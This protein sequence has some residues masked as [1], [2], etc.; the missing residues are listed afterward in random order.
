[1]KN[2][3]G[4]MTGFLIG[5]GSFLLLF[6]FYFL[7]KI[8]PSDEL[9]PGVLVLSAVSFGVVMAYSGSNIQSYFNNRSSKIKLHT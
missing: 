2:I 4:K 9:A 5:A 1:M 7:S 6:R 3:I 8:S